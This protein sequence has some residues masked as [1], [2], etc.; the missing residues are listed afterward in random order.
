MDRYELL[1]EI[2]DLEESRKT[3]TFSIKSDFNLLI[4]IIIQILLYILLFIPRIFAFIIFLFFNTKKSKYYMSKLFVEPFDIFKIIID[5]YFEAK[6]T[7]YL[8]IFLII[9]FFIQIFIIEANFNINNF[10]YSFYDLLDGNYYSIIT[11]IFLHANLTHLLGNLLFLIIFGRIVEK[12]FKGWTFIIFLIS[13]II[14]NL[15]S[16][17]FFYLAGDI[18][19]S[20]GA[21]GGI[22]GLIILAILL[23]PFTF[24]S[25]FIIPLPIFLVGWFFIISDTIGLF[26]DTSSHINHMAHLSGYLSLIILFFAFN[27]KNRKKVISGLIINLVFIVFVYLLV[28][29]VGITNILSLVK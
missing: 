6:T 16:G 19:P 25:A 9:I 1:K 17:Y 18:T 26:N 28:K 13:G 4:K 2:Q 7:A 15:I 29:I 23:E 10:L 21:S 20:L 12:H 22:A 5:W 27:I 24:T 8:S 3:K 11:S 14:A